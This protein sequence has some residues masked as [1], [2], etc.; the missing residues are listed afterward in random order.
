MNTYSSV[1]AV[2]TA[3]GGLEPASVVFGGIAL[4]AKGLEMTRGGKGTFLR[5]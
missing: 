5:T 1:A 3:F 2:G 4:G